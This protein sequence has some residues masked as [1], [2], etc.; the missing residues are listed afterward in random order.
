MILRTAGD[1]LKLAPA[2]RDAVRRVDAN[3]AVVNLDSMANQVGDS[4]WRERMFVH[5]TSTFGLLAL[6]LACVGLYGTIA[7]GVGR[8]RAEIAVRV[9]L[10]AARSQILWMVLRRA[11]LLAAAG[12]VLGIPLSLWSGRFV[13]TQLVGV[14]PRDPAAF[15]SAAAILIA[16][17][18]LAGYIPARRATLIEPAVA[19]KQE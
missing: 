9:A 18:G 15:A 5:L 16:V 2:A 6:A 11:L 12:V 10:G 13:A 4:L 1:P 14:T 19:L 3:I 8:R 7:Y 17:A